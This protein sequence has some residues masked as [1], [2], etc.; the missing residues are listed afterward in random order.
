MSGKTK[1]GQHDEELVSFSGRV[2]PELLALVKVTCVQKGCTGM[3]LIRKGVETEAIRERVIVDGEISP[4]FK[5]SYELQ[6]EIIKKNRRDH[7][8][9]KKGAKK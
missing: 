8:L 4:E 3:D 6:L 2:T 9:R 7:L 5:Q 1:H